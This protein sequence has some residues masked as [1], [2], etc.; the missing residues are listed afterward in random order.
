MSRNVALAIK[1][2]PS[3][4]H[5]NLRSRMVKASVLYHKI[6]H[7]QSMSVQILLVLIWLSEKVCQFTCCC[8][9][10]FP[11]PKKIKKIES[12]HINCRTVGY[13]DIFQIN[14]QIKSIVSRLNGFIQTS[15]ARS[16]LPKMET[17]RSWYSLISPQN[18]LK[19]LPY[20]IS[21]NC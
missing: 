20:P 1:I 14:K 15:W 3:W 6:F 9:S 10:V 18:G 19:S 11:P 16:T 21:A 12:H 8:G 7:H 5:T 13:G 2:R 4:V 17:V